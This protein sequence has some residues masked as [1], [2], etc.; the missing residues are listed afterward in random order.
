MKRLNAA[1]RFACLLATT[2]AMVFFSRAESSN[3]QKQ[4]SAHAI[5][6]MDQNG[7]TAVS[8]VPSGGGQIFDVAVGKGGDVFVPD[9][10]NISV[11]DTVRWTW[12]ESGHSV[13]S[14]PPCVPDS[15][16]CS[17][18]DMNCFPGVT[19]EVGH[20]Y[21]HTFSQSGTYAYHCI[22]HCII[23]MTGVV[24]VSGGCAPPG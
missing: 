23:G 17:P 4:T 19:S 24:N 15:Q 13:T 12:A 11:G 7:R 3:K 8:G 21:T 6:I 14:G 16:Y 9:S 22:V 2:F 20:V 18:D 1:I 10:V 5:H